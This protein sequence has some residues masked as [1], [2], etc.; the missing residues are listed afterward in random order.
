MYII[1][2]AINALRNELEKPNSLLFPDAVSVDQT[3][4]GEFY[5]ENKAMAP[6]PS[7]S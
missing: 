1:S 7:I 6:C 5:S 2:S 3:I 4:S